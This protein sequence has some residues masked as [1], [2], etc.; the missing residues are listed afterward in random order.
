MT[1]FDMYL[2]FLRKM[3]LQA[4]RLISEVCDEG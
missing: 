3:M 4:S 2:S 1:F